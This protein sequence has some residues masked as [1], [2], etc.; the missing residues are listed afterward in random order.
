MN[1]AWLPDVGT[2]AYS[3][4]NLS[5]NNLQ[6]EN[7]KFRHHPSFRVLKRGTA[8]GWRGGGGGDGKTKSR[9]RQEIT[10]RE[11]KRAQKRRRDERV[12]EQMSLGKI[13]QTQI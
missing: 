8:R 11:S 3:C 9:K 4:H 13:A 6:D 2:K 10:D 12:R 7:A 5:V 1:L